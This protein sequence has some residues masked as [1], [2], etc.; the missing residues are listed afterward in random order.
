MVESD[1]VSVTGSLRPRP[2]FSIRQWIVTEAPPSALETEMKKKKSKFP[3][4]VAVLGLVVV[5]AMAW[6]KRDH[7]NPV[8]PGSPAP[9]FYAMDREGD[10]VGLSDFE[11][12]VVL[13]NVWATWCPPCVEEMPSMQRLYEELEDENF[14]IVAVSVDAQR[15]QRDPAG[16]PGGNVWAFADDL[17]LTFPI[18]HDPEQR[19]QRIYQTTGVPESFVIGRDGIIYRKVSGEAQWDAPQYVDFIRRLLEG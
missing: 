13:L 15:G 3:Y 8:G 4:V 11:D 17:G 1:P 18:L 2:L 5:V 16:N 7:F 10:R 14:E 6:V 19:I 9:E 12:H